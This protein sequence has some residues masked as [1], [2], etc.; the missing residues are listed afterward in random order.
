MK[1]R[2]GITLLSILGG[3]VLFLLLAWF[4]V[5]RA[6]EVP[7]YA[8][9]PR[10]LVIAHQGGDGL[11]PG[12]TLYAYQHAADLGADVLE[13]DVHMTKD[14]TLVLSHDETVD[15]TT[16]G[17]GLIEDLT[18]DEIK[19]LDAGCDWTADEGATHPYR[20]QG[21]TISTLEEIF[22]AFPA[23]RMLMEI[24]KVSRPIDQSLCKLIQKYDMQDK[25]IVASFDDEA[26]DHFRQ[27]CPGIATSGAR[28]EVKTFVL[29]S[30]V[31]LGFLVSPRFQ[32]LQVP[33]E[34][35]GITIMTPAFVRAA[36]RRNLHVEPWTIDDPQQ[37]QD[38]ID[39]GVDGII[40]DRPDVMLEIL[41]R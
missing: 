1:S 24:K 11:W 28:N 27:V 21:I 37:L 25:V 6:A 9:A 35:S 3:L 2:V 7:Y 13:M 33:A 30:K 18:L 15:R 17:T 8:D 39:W 20:G 36:H 26:L 12:D 5:P 19:A 14:G 31:G 40:T 4:L 32:S 22:E 38:Y 41:G 16:D 34:S 10:P 23:K 29:L